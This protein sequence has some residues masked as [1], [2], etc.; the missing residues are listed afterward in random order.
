MLTERGSGI[1]LHVSSL[2]SLG[3]IGD[4]GPS[5]YAFADFL[6]AA[7]QQYWQV[8]PL[9]PTGYG[10]SPYSALSAFAGNPLFISIET[11]TAAGWL[12]A[13]C[14][15]SAPSALGPVDFESAERW[16][17]PLLE[18]AARHFGERAAGDARLRFDSF[19][20]ENAFWLEDYA[21]FS[22]LRKRFSGRSWPDWRA[23]Y[24]RHEPEALSRLNSEYP[25]ER[26][27]EKTIQFFFEDQ[28]QALRAYCRERKIRLVGDMAIFVNYDSAD[29]W[30]HPEIFEL[31]GNRR[32]V[33]VS[34]VP[35]DYFSPTGQRWGNPLYRW[36]VLASKDFDW[37]DAR[38]RRALALCDLLR[39]DH[40]RGFE[41]YW[42]IPAEEET[43]VRGKWMKALGTEFFAHLHRELGDLPLI[44]EDLGVITP[45]VERM[46]KSFGLPG[47]RVMQF[48]FADR[49]AHIHLP[50]SME[51]NMVVYTGTHDNDT[52][53]GWWRHANDT[54]REAVQ[55]YLHP[56]ED[57][58]V[59]AMMR[60]ASSS[61]ARLC[62]FPMQDVL[63][64]DSTARMNTPAQSNGNWA[65]RY[66]AGALEPWIAEKLSAL[67][68][69]TD[70]DGW[71]DPAIEVA[72]SS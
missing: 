66:S 30:V 25:A 48:G 10:N 50:H 33:H 61:V 41:A 52:T 19:C 63:G 9:G 65:W 56:G 64:L 15:R 17:R 44:A 62:L 8:L 72:P 18:E 2:P 23:E 12:D 54:E 47:M 7:E 38:V 42:S 68:R 5:A 28:W 53:L 59:W 40:F 20:R 21:S 35:P 55:A 31:D 4:L 57:G 58:I 6:S 43:A 32:A 11:L 37:W 24:L 16:K 69:V 22:V 51:E 13:D 36:D 34:G 27:V 67:T 26:E 1:L 60:A 39:L 70:R 3:G 71:V 29:V 45:E 49:G 46:R 14:L